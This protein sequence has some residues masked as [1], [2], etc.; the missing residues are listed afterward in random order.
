M[1]NLLFELQ[2]DEPAVD[3]FLQIFHETVN[4]LEEHFQEEEQFYQ[5]HAPQELDSHREQHQHFLKT[6]EHRSNDLNDEDP[7]TLRALCDYFRDWLILHVLDFDKNTAY[8][9]KSSVHN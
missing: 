6:L 8:H 7:E 2:E 4:H 1:L 3:V 5:T 9:I